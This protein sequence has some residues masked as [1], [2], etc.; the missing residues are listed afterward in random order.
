MKSKHAK[1]V[2]QLD[3]MRESEWLASSDLIAT[4]KESVVFTITCMEVHEGAEMGQGRRIDGGSISFDKVK[5][6]LFLNSTNRKA[7]RRLFGDKAEDIIGQKV[8][9]YVDHKVRG[10]G[11]ECVDGLRIKGANEK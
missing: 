10:F 11:G 9:V 8:T 7:I 1:T 2:S 5:R 3:A 6:K 4:G